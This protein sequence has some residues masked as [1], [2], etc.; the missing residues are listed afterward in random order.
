[1]AKA[2]RVPGPAPRVTVGSVRRKLL[3]LADACGAAS[4]AMGRRRVARPQFPLAEI[5]LGL[6]RAFNDAE[7]RLDELI[8]R[9]RTARPVVTTRKR[10]SMREETLAFADALDEAARLLNPAGRKARARRVA[11]R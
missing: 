7:R 11:Q 2:K 9:S 1:M 4:A 5:M 6:D 3:S 8:A 10:A